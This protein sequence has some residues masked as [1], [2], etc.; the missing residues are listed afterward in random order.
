MSIRKPPLS[1]A[2]QG[3]CRWCDKSV[4]PRLKKD[5]TPRKR[6]PTWHKECLADWWGAVDP[7]RLR[8]ALITRDGPGCGKCRTGED[9]KYITYPHEIDHKVALW[10]VARLSGKERRWYFTIS[11]LWILCIPCHLLK[12]NKEAA[13]RAH[14]KTLGEKRDGTWIGK[15]SRPMQSRGF[16]RRLRK[17]MDGTVERR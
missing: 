9:E 15:K 13:E 7:T 16:D 5:G 10:K 3:M 4:P 1:P 11:N 2:I 14:H 6:Q 12:S 8:G 17:R